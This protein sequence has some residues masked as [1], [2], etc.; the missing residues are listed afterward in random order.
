MPADMRWI[1]EWDTSPFEGGE[2]C[3]YAIEARHWCN[4]KTA[5]PLDRPEF[6][7]SHAGKAGFAPRVQRS[8]L[9]ISHDMERR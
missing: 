8:P 4:K 7:D 3:C 2:F 6:E 5:Q 1:A 9:G